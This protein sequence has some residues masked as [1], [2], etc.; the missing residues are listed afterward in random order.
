M[1]PKHAIGFQLMMILLFFI[2]LFSGICRESGVFCT[3]QLNYMLSGVRRTPGTGIGFNF[4]S[5]ISLTEFDT[6]A[7]QKLLFEFNTMILIYFLH[8]TESFLRS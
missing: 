8:G 1:S 6:C 7:N 4:F 2:C 5:S 3:L